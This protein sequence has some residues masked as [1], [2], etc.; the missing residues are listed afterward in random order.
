MTLKVNGAR[1]HTHACRAFGGN[2]VAGIYGLGLTARQSGFVRANGVRYNRFHGQHTVAN[3]TDRAAKPYGY[4][5]GAAWELPRKAGAIGSYAEAGITLDATGSGA[6]GKNAQGTLEII[7]GMSGTG[8]LISSASGT[9]GISLSAA[10]ALFASKA[11]VGTATITF[12]ATGTSTALG[13]TGGTAGT[14][15]SATWTPYAIGWISGTTAEA[16]LTPT[17][18]S[19]AVWSKA[20][21]G[22]FSAEQLLRIISAYA[23][24]AATGLE[25]A[26]PQFTGVDGVTLR[27]DGTYNAGTRTIDALDGD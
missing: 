21:E 24:G 14:A 3:V 8:G 2:A 13:H 5:P 15:L 1:L 4:L 20:I 18:I 7:F 27:I 23:A 22:G 25:G 17:G 9:A 19:N 16:G 12:D 6:M 26:N 11:V 10:A